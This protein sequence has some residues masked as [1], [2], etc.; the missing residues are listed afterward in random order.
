MHLQV[1]RVIFIINHLSGN[2]MWPVYFSQTWISHHTCHLFFVFFFAFCAALPWGKV[3]ITKFLI[4]LR[5]R[6]VAFAESWKL[7]LKFAFISIGSRNDSTRAEC[8][9]HSWL[10]T[11]TVSAGDPDSVLRVQGRCTR[12][13]TGCLSSTG[14]PTTIALSSLQWNLFW[15]CCWSLHSAR[16][17]AN[18]VHKS[19]TQVIWDS[20]SSESSQQVHAGTNQSFI[21][22]LLHHPLKKYLHFISYGSIRIS[23]RSLS[24]P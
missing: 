16:T 6:W 4:I 20:S 21:H 5:K 11:V 19:S 13:P 12:W 10:W 3:C 17:S 2:V 15:H 7:A 1:K 9:T 14:I 8:F 24:G 23:I 22:Q 18:V